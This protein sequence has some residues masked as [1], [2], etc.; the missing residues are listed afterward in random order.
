[1][2]TLEDR[3][4]H[5]FD[6]P[7][8]GV[9]A[10]SLLDGVRHGAARRQARRRAGSLAAVVTLGVAGVVG[11]SLDRPG[12]PSPAPAPTTSPSGT[13]SS[14][15]PSSTPSASSTA[16]G[17]P[18]HISG[19]FAVDA[20]HLWRISQERCNGERCSLISSGDGTGTWSPVQYVEWQG[21]QGAGMLSGPIS[22][23]RM[24]ADG[25]DGWAWGDQFWVTHDAGDSWDLSSL[26]EV[27]LQSPAQGG[28]TGAAYVVDGTAMRVYSAPAGSD[29]WSPV[30][31]PADV[32]GIQGV[33]ATDDTVLVAAQTRGVAGGLRLVVSHDGLATTTTVGY[34][35]PEPDPYHL[36]A[37]KH[38]FFFSC[39]IGK[40]TS[41]WTSPDG[42]QWSELA[43]FQTK[44]LLAALVPVGDK[45]ALVAVDALSGAGPTYRVTT[46]GIEQIALGLDGT[47][48]VVG[49]SFIDAQNGYLVV[50]HAK[51]SLLLV[52]SDGGRT[53]SSV[54]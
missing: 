49:G 40:T 37:S 50:Y 32:V 19:V 42:E 27:P 26:K 41:V 2:N 39:R 10:T 21:S 15:S 54:D 34:P 53:W 20:S 29:S 8:H 33:V 22:Q 35:C 36:T 25:R 5:S 48:R 17:S 14:P 7:V 16:Q 24:S 4:R 51:Q 1:M 43:A 31:L 44:E 28:G 47:P 12:T 9:D 30:T 38:T 11:I 23:I 18:S 13:P 3:I 52:T 46:D 6:E 45:A